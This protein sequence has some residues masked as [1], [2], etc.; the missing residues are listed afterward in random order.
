MGA[1]IGK[2]FALFYIYLRP[3]REPVK[4][5]LFYT[6]DIASNYYSLNEEES[7]HCQK[8]LRLHE[9]DLIHLTDGKG[10]LYEACIIDARSRQ[11]AVEVAS[12]ME[13]YGRRYYSLHLAVAPTKNIDRFEWFLEKATEIGVDEITPLICEHSERRQLRNDRLEKIIT[14]AVKQSLKAYHPVLHPLADYNKFIGEK[15][16]GQLFIAHLVENDPIL[17]HKVYHKAGPVTI[18][19][20]PEGDFSDA[21]IAVA[22]K[23][24]YQ[25]ISLGNSRLRTETAA[26]VACHA[27]AM[28]NAG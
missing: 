15:R 9:G 17:L 8:V 2:V 22:I 11:V 3:L 27:V 16:E 6:P 19:I 24:S 14:S 21:E 26:V 23:A 28:I 18:L 10:T 7:R 1:K 20:G 25:C 5:N 13:N 4:M 12:R